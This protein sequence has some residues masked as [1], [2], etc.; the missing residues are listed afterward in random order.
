MPTFVQEDAV[1][2]F[3]A[4]LDGRGLNEATV[5]IRD[6]IG[7]MLDF[8]ETVRA[9]DG[10][11]D[12]ADMLLFQWGTYDRKIPSPR[13]RNGWHGLGLRHQSRAA[14]DSRRSGGRR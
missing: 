3:R 13:R 7:A 9:S 11:S 5:S 6:G 10:T 12:S 1:Q 14:V 4:F 2:A 8:Y